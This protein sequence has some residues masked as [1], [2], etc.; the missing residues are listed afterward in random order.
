MAGPIG[1]K[2]K[3]IDVS[4]S[5]DLFSAEIIKK[6]AYR[7]L[8]KASVE[9]T[10]DD[11]SITCRLAFPDALSENAADRIAS[12]LRTEVLDQDLRKLV[13]DET[14]TTRNA[15]LAYAFSRT[16]LQEGD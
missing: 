7:I 14:E 3:S 10:Q 11:A 2:L 9:L 1:G 13:A 15:I 5:S 12:E 16:G 4:F 8:D 6:A